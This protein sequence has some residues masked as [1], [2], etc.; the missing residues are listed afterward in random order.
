LTTYP[1]GGPASYLIGSEGGDIWQCTLTSACERTK[2]GAWVP[3]GL[4]LTAMAAYGS[5]GL[6]LLTRS[7]KPEEGNHVSVRLLDQLGAGGRVRDEMKMS[8]PL[9]V[10][11]FEGIAASLR[12]DGVLRLYLLSDDNGSSTQRT[13]LLSFDWQTPR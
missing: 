6:A 8:A 5:D 4:S 3:A 13:Y 12:P 7:Y 1:A 10:D 9:T 11:N 2:L